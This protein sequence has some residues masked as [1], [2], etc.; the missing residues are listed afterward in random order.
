[1][2]LVLFGWIVQQ[3]YFKEL[4][5]RGYRDLFKKDDEEEYDVLGFGYSSGS[6]MKMFGT[7]K[8]S[9]ED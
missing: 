4:V 7:T 9:W 5:N 6:E 1:M 2:N 8:Y 3:E